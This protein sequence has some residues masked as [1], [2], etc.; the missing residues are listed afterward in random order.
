MASLAPSMSQSVALGKK[1]D[2]SWQSF[3]KGDVKHPLAY[4]PEFLS[5]PEVFRLPSDHEVDIKRANRDREAKGRRPIR[6][7]GI[8][9]VSKPIIV[10][11]EAK[12][13]LKKSMS[14]L[15]TSQSF[16]MFFLQ[17]GKILLTASCCTSGNQSQ[18]T[19]FLAFQIRP[20]L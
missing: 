5:R 7:G 20:V 14:E 17:N 11:A 9:A 12:K 19:I 16:Q 3:Q 2:R 4:S 6:P 13:L 10:S 18:L 1:R 8:L 15:F